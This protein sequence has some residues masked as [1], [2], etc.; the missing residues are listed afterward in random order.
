MSFQDNDNSIPANVDNEVLSIVLTVRETA[1]PGEI[2]PIQFIDGAR[3]QGDAVRNATTS[4]G[5]LVDPSTAKSFF[6]IQGFMGVV[7]DV[8]LFVRGDEA[9][10]SWRV[11]D[12]LLDHPCEPYPYAAGTWGP[13]TLDPSLALGG[14]EWTGERERT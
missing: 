12:D 13:A 14:I 11:F 10:A 2:K 9:E 4:F 1:P 8:T 5:T 7:A 6:M 3:G